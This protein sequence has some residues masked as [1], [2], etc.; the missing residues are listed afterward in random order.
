MV[1][2]SATR[3]EKQKHN[4]HRQAYRFLLHN[5]FQ[6][7]LLPIRQTSLLKPIKRL[8]MPIPLSQESISHIFISFN[9]AVN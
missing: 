2:L 7:S 1:N 8:Y 6:N 3:D 4:D 9:L 5:A